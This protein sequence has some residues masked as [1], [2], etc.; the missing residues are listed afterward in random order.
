MRMAIAAALALVPAST[1]GAQT[2]PASTDLA[3]ATPIAGNWSYSATADGSE[4]VFSNTSSFAQLW[5]HCAR[6]TRRVSI[7]K[8]ATGAAP[9]LTVWTS[10]LTQSVAASFNP[11][12]GRLS[13]EFGAFDPLLDAITSSRGRVG[14]SVANQP[15]LVVPPWAEAARVIEDCRA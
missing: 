14:F 6:S 8:P 1:L 9:F 4:A 5:V 10:S 2:I 13:I 12:T 11:T 7:A 15:A 3:S